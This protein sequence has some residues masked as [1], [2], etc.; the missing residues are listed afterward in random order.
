MSTLH[1]NVTAQA[2]PL[3]RADAF[4]PG[5]TRLTL[6][7][8]PY[9]LVRD[10]EA[11]DRLLSAIC[12]HQ[13][14]IVEHDTSPDTLVCP[15]HH[16]RFHAR[17]GDCRNAP[18]QRLASYPV[19]EHEGALYARLPAT[20]RAESAAA[21]ASS[22]RA[23]DTRSNARTA[24]DV[25]VHLHA[26]ACLEV[27]SGDF[28]LL[29]DPWL[30]GPAFLG[31]WI[32]YPPTTANAAALQPDAI[33]ISHEH[34]D[35]FHEPTLKHFDR[36]TPIYVPD[37]PNRR[38]VQ[39]LETLGFKNVTAMP[40]GQAMTIGG[41]LR[42]TCYEPASLWNDAILL[43]ETSDWRLL[44]LNDAG[45]QP[46][47][48][49]AVGPV[50]AVASAFTHG[51][52]GFPQTWSHLS[53]EDKHNIMRRSC[54]GML[55]MLRS[56]VELYQTDALLPFAGHFSLWH[57]SH[58]PFVRNMV[59]HGVDAVVEALSDLDVDVID[60]LPGE[61]WHIAD[62]R[63]DRR[64]RQRDRLYHRTQLE[65]YLNRAFRSDAFAQ[66]HPLHR[67]I[68]PDAVATH[69][70][71][72]NDVPEIGFCEDMT[73]LLRATDLGHSETHFE[74]PFE[75][76]A[77]ALHVLSHLNESPRMTMDV[78]R[79]VLAA[80]VQDDLSW[81]EAHIGYWCRFH[82]DPDIFHA[83]FWRLLQAPYYQRPAGDMPTGAHTIT[84]RSAIAA[85]L[86]QHGPH[87]QRILARA[88]LHC[89]ACAHAPAETLEQGA[90]I[91]GLGDDAIDRL[92]TELQLACH[93]RRTPTAQRR[94]S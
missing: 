68:E 16:W 24:S 12:P 59:R 85:I 69:L 38:L 93:G 82:R 26:H 51:A 13:G 40:F 60:M 56:A 9:F 25:T 42:L 7:G 70:E 71:R 33:W 20:A 37:F 41:D 92:V 29:T 8:R 84:R 10:P 53:D 94:A 72:L 30:H 49:E 22:S 64:W 5:T 79:G 76:R 27:R 2:T 44:N 73:V 75:V 55:R 1:S 17:T 21:T 80:V 63:I 78:P 81:D 14:G 54:D 48:A 4:A 35:H 77:G 19:F 39:R 32:Q 57:P 34:S 62:E 74:L 67:T 65:R 89:A 3:G 15:N 18:N 6:A 90:R 87:A 86:E 88:G 11:G 45:L 61:S 43:I 36:A 46:R 23:A 47:I 58:R 66:H 83:G 31:A 52:S 28:S 91:H 50:D